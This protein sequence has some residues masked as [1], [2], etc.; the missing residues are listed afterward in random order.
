LPVSDC[1]LVLITDYQMW[2]TNDSLPIPFVPLLQ[3][4]RQ[5]ARQK[6]RQTLTDRHN[7]HTGRQADKQ[8]YRE[9]KQADI[10]AGRQTGR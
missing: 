3:T 10:Q 5:G 7:R 6:D 1:H 8:A 9:Y 2:Q 4:D